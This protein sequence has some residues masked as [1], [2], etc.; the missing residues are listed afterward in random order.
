MFLGHCRVHAMVC[1]CMHSMAMG[2]LLSNSLLTCFA[3]KP[4]GLKALSLGVVVGPN[5]LWGR[6]PRLSRVQN[7]F[8]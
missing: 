4:W 7:G 1:D 6:E 3:P 5:G 8:A 2:V